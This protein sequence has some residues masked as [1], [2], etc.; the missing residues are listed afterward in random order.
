MDYCHI[1]FSYDTHWIKHCISIL[2]TSV[3]M[4]CLPLKIFLIYIYICLVLVLLF[5]FILSIFHVQKNV[6]Y[7]IHLLYLHFWRKYP[8]GDFLILNKPNFFF[9]W[10]SNIL[11]G[12]YILFV[13]YLVIRNFANLI[14]PK[15]IF[16]TLIDIL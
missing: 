4:V 2:S 15:N 10:R 11:L 12:F 16:K 9:K 8:T 5:S 6:K 1:W 14:L 3:K 7:L 13:L